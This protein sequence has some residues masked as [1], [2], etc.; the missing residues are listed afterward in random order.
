MTNVK[1]FRKGNDI[2]GFLIKGHANTGAQGEYD[3]VC[4]AVSGIAY[5]AL[6]ALDEMCGI[7]TFHETNGKIEMMLPEFLEEA[8]RYKATIIME[9]MEIGLKQIELQ[10]PR[11]IRTVCK[12]V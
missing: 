8:L 5:T 11:Y 9:A 4:A 7:R 1:V 6:G 10:Y 3:M 12:E 2:Q